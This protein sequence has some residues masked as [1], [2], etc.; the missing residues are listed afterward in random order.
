MHSH[1]KLPTEVVE[2]DL[3]ASMVVQVGQVDQ[4]GHAFF[5]E[6]STDQHEL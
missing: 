4:T 3:Y 5:T 6:E 1:E 2:L